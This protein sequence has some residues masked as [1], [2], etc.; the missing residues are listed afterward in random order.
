VSFKGREL[1][2]IPQ[3]FTV[4]NAVGTTEARRDQ[5][6]L[7]LAWALSVHKSQ[8]Q[9]LEKVKVDLRRT[10]ESGQAYVA[11]SRATSLEGL[12]VLNFHPSKV[13]AHPRVLEWYRSGHRP[14]HTTSEEM[15]ADEAIAAYY[16]Q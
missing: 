11:L 1:L 7:I 5:V 16:D 6:P 10:F 15:D 9:T 14:L 2:C 13:S 3:Q 8:G 12:Q 4:N